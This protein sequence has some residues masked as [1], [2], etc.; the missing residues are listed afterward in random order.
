MTFLIDG[1]NLLHALGL[2][3]R[4]MPKGQLQKA[5]SRLLDWLCT[6]HGATAGDVC[7]VFDARNA[8]RTW[9]EDVVSGVRVRYSTGEF[10]DDLIE[11]T[12]AAEAQPRQLAVISN[13]NRLQ[14]AARRRGCISWT[15]DEYVDWLQ[16]RGATKPAP[17]TDE[18][19][20]PVEPSAVELKEWLRIFGKDV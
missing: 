8:E 11:Q 3:N 6:S 13:D 2:A 9:S 17:V 4:R 19:D 1:Y 16:T 7:V 10:A 18:P 20:K 12:I 15:S 5:R 14:E